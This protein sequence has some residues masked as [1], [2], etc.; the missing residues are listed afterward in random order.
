VAGLGKDPTGQLEEVLVQKRNILGE[1]R[2]LFFEEVEVAVTVAP[3]AC[4]DRVHENKLVVGKGFGRGW[5]TEDHS[6]KLVFGD[7]L[8]NFFE[9]GN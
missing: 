4:K 6:L 3:V 8:E 9:R 7:L 1:Q 5:K 2:G